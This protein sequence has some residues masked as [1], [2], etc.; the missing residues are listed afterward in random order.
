MQRMRMHASSASQTCTQ[1]VLGGG[2]L[3]CTVAAAV[4]HA[5]SKL[6]AFLSG[7]TLRLSG[8]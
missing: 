4:P 1:L 3:P 5:L 6:G 8:S 7:R 2:V